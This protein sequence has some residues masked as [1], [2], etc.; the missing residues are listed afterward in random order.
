MSE[1]E[2][3]KIVRK[4]QKGD[5][6]AF[7]LIYDRYLERIYRFIFLKVSNREEAQDLT[8]QVFLKAWESLPQFKFTRAPFVSWLYRIA[9]NL[10]TDFYRTQKPL[11]SLEGE[12][13]I[14]PV[15][16]PNWEEKLEIH[17]FQDQLREALNQLTENQREII[18]FR[19]VEELSYREIAK[20]LKKSQPALRILQFRALR[21]LKQ[22]LKNKEKKEE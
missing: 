2:I 14:D 18:F 17:Q 6:L 20:I 3:R 8:Q 9:R 12:L 5:A 19:F 11:L 4:A 7:G 1:K 22:L 16:Y 13:K 15:D 21:K 10:V